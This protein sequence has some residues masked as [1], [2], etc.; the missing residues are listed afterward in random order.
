MRKYILQ[1]FTNNIIEYIL[2]Q[3]SLTTPNVPINVFEA[4]GSPSCLRQWK[5]LIIML[6]SLAQQET[7]AD[8]R[9]NNVSLTVVWVICGGDFLFRL[10]HGDNN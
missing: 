6:C 4:V 5:H 9:L 1:H 3:G 10:H 8:F 2:F 7:R